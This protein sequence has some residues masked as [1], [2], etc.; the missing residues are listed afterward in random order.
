MTCTFP[1]GQLSVQ[2]MVFG[3]L[4]PGPPSSFGKG[5]AGGTGEYDRARG[6]VHAYMIAPGARRFTIGLD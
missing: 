2:G 6:S 4:I 3:H 5:I 1:G